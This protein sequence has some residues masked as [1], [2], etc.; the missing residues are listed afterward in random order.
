MEHDFREM[1][2]NSKVRMPATMLTEPCTNG[3]AGAPMDSI[4]PY[5]GWPWLLHFDAFRM[6]MYRIVQKPQFADEQLQQIGLTYQLPSCPPVGTIL[7]G[8]AVAANADP[9]VFVVQSDS[10]LGMVGSS[11]SSSWGMVLQRFGPLT[12]IGGVPDE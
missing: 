9:T 11:S 1:D 4:H 6:A 12:V 10:A 8:I 3:R 2:E 5:C 7:S